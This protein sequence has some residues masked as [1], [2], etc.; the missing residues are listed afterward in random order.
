MKTP[1]IAI[2]LCTL[3]F[4]PLACDIGATTGCDFR[5]DSVNGPEPRCQ[6]RSGLQG[7][8]TFAATCSA[9]SGEALDGGCPVEGIVAGCALQADESVIDWYYAPKTVADVEADCANEGEVVQP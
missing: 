9:L 2:A 5:K 7:G 4:S 3:L 6:E 1:M 8:E